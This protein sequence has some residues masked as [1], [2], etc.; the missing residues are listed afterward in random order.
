MKLLNN[1]ILVLCI[2]FY[3][4]TSIFAQCDTSK[5]TGEYKNLGLYGGYCF[6]LSFSQ[7]SSR[8]F[9]GVKSYPFSLLYSDDTCKTWHKAFPIDSLNFE[10][11]QRGW[12]G[13]A[14]SILANQKDWV[15]ARS[16]DGV[17]YLSSVFISFNDGDSAT[18]KTV[19]DPY[20]LEVMGYSINNPVI[21]AIDLSE[22]HIVSACNN[23]IVMQDSS[24]SLDSSNV[25]K[26]EDY[27]TLV[28]SF[29]YVRSLAISN[30]SSGF[31]VFFALDT[32]SDTYNGLNCLLYKFDGDTAIKINLLNTT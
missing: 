6:D 17:S 8:I 3:H 32:L 2:I 25:F 15:V 28:S 26:V 22:H 16:I 11:G 12:G 10:C 24:L 18:W 9:A 31:P 21:R 20:L 27:I 1:F 5:T 4:S 13:G 14:F 23:Y 29:K 30:D 19:V 7:S